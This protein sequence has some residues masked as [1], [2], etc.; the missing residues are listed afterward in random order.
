MS[1]GLLRIRPA[2]P[3]DAAALAP[4]F[5]AILASGI[6]SWTKD[7]DAVLAD[8]IAHPDRIAV[9]VVEADGG[10]GGVQSLRR[11][12]GDTRWGVPAG[13]GIIGTHLAPEMQGRGAGRRLFAQSRQ[14]A[15]AAGLRIIVASISA[16]SAQA[17]GYYRAMGFR[18]A[19]QEGRIIHHL[20]ELEP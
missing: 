2:R 4:V 10:L 16:T 15:R 17:L 13:W 7:A 14:A 19:R 9:H 11:S 12:T 6:R 3:E 18:P 1:E 5:D 20:L 8:Y